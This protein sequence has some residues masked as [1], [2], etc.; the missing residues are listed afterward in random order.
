MAQ[1]LHT[2][3]VLTVI[4]FVHTSASVARELRESLDHNPAAVSTTFRCTQF[5]KNKSYNL[6]H[7]ETVSASNVHLVAV[8]AYAEIAPHTLRTFFPASSAIVSVALVDKLA[9]S[10]AAHGSQVALLPPPTA[11]LVAAGLALALATE[12]AAAAFLPTL[13]TVVVVV[14]QVRAPSVA[15]LLAFLAAGLLGPALGLVHWRLVAAVL[16]ALAARADSV[17]RAAL[18]T[19][20]AVLVVAAE[21]Y[22]PMVA[23][24]RLLEPPM[25]LAGRPTGLGAALRLCQH[26]SGAD[27]SLI[28]TNVGDI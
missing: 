10:L 3:Y 2:I 27:R 24:T 16:L 6:G 11:V 8:S 5:P 12:A 13:P 14:L 9:F 26:A 15:A 18:T 17:L 7:I 4:H 28:L 23:A 21:V 20:A 22:T 19:P 25:A 1:L